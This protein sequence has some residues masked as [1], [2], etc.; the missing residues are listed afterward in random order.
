[1]TS[2][3]GQTFEEPVFGRSR[4]GASFLEDQTPESLLERELEKAR[5]PRSMI[6]KFFDFFSRGQYASVSFFETLLSGERRPLERLGAAFRNA[7]SEFVSPKRRRSCVDVLRELSPDFAQKH[8]YLTE[9]FGVQCDIGLD[10]TT[11]LSF[12]LSGAGKLVRLGGR[13]AALSPKGEHV[14]QGLLRALE[15][16]KADQIVAEIV[17][18]AQEEA[19]RVGKQ[20]E[21]FPL[22]RP[23]TTV[24]R[25]ASIPEKP[26][27]LMVREAAERKLAELVQSDPSLI[28]PE[29]LRVRFFGKEI[30]SPRIT[31]PVLRFFRID[32]AADA[33]RNSRFVLGSIRS[34]LPQEYRDLVRELEGRLTESKAEVESIVQN[35]FGNLSKA[36]REKIGR[37][38]SLI[39]DETRRAE[40]RA[41]R[42]LT[43][44]EATFLRQ[45]LLEENPLE[46]DEMAAFASM[47]QVLADVAEIETRGQMLYDQLLN[48]SPRVYS[49][50]S[51]PEGLVFLKKRKFGLTTFLGASE[52]RMFQTLEQAMKAGYVPEF[53]AAMMLTQ[54]LLTSR[55]AMA[56]RMFNEAVNAIFGKIDDLLRSPVQEIPSQTAKR[57]R[58]RL[59]IEGD[60]RFIGE[61]LYGAGLGEAERALLRFFDSGLNAFRTLATVVRPAFGPRNLA[62]NSIMMFMTEGLRILKALDPRSLIDAGFLLFYRPLFDERLPRVLIESIARHLQTTDLTAT[63]A[64]ILRA[65]RQ[66]S[67]VHRLIGIRSALGDFY[68]GED[69]LTAARRFGVIKDMDIRGQTAYR[70]IMRHL[71]TPLSERMKD[72]GS[73]VD[74]FLPWSRI[75]G[76]IEDMGRLTV[77]IN[78]LR[79][80]HSPRVAADLVNRALFDYG[81]GLSRIEA[82]VARRVLPFYSFLRFAI[83]AVLGAAL[84]HPGRVATLA[85]GGRLLEAFTKIARGEELNESERRVLP[86]Y[87][88]AQPS[89]F[90]GF[91][92]ERKATFRVFNNFSPTDIFSLIQ[93]DERTGQFDAKKTAVRSML[94]A[95]APFIKIPFEMAL[96][97]NFFTD[98]AV[99]SMGRVGNAFEW[100]ESLP[101]AVRD[102]LGY[103][104]AIDPRT[105]QEQIYV[106]P[107]LAYIAATVFPPMNDIVRLGRPELTPL[108][109]AEAILFG[110]GVIKVDLGR[111]V[112]MRISVFRRELLELQKQLADAVR[113]G[114]MS[115]VAQ[116]Q[117]ELQEL[118]DSYVQEVRSIVLPEIRSPAPAVYGGLS[119]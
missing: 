53:D 49:I 64:E 108:Q 102:L 54:R 63:A 40:A 14:F 88:L 57:I 45:R 47:R 66:A 62:S 41:G 6:G 58:K 38:A 39:D 68:T 11:Y 95:A 99:S 7:F 81:H 67:P 15:K 24:E 80:G 12:G 103:E 96:D 97:R 22:A 28:F 98:K 1:M 35:I 109:K 23:E 118:M 26:T 13:V 51:K 113:T 111:E 112:Q 29:G 32:R 43:D 84:Q 42:R 117:R 74:F 91:D 73:L 114:R 37:I 9:I 48:Y 60:V 56:H 79:L 101:Q 105:G 33:I 90:T 65:H 72:F 85:K 61:G 36:Q 5:E 106:H 89:L 83:P 110:T 75:P 20:L 18:P 3:L 31:Q 25:V 52:A 27:A 94:A 87:I 77:F 70:E 59:A 115:R 46:P 16:E 19:E 82:R 86:P 69:I 8:P 55:R 71:P 104:R 34:A 30:L 116:L 78:G 21:L 4:L 10:P 44:E 119:P 50:L 2:R 76:V 17:R 92:E 100:L 107:Y 93:V